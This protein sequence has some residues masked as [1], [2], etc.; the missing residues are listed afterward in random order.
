MA[1]VTGFTSERMLEI[2]NE[3]VVDGEI[4]GDNLIL[5]TREGTPIDAGNVRG[6]IGPTGPSG[7]VSSVNDQTGPVYSPRIFT[8]KAALDSQWGT[9]PAGAQA[10]TTT[11]NCGW[12]RVGGAWEVN[13]PNRIFT[14]KAALDAQL[15]SAPN[16]SQAYTTAE[17]TSWIRAGGA[18]VLN[19]PSRVFNDKAALDSGW[20]NAPN[21]ARAFTTV[22]QQPW[23]YLTGVWCPETAAGRLQRGQITSVSSN[24]AIV[25]MDNTIFNRGGC[26]MVNGE[27]TIPVTGLYYVFASVP[28]INTTGNGGVTGIVTCSVYNNSGPLCRLAQYANFW[29][30][31]TVSSLNYLGAGDA[32]KMALG[33]THQPSWADPAAGLGGYLAIGAALVSL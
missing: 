12:I 11:E 10:Y 5:L 4:Q 26:A 23:V 22:D 32:I 31:L 25:S 7:G 17:Q 8:N 6:P 1:K 24:E 20:S 9:A 27:L 16:G 3:T 21:G 18:W 2:E 30:A 28:T 13:S 29:P 33:C 19:T 15:P 14:N